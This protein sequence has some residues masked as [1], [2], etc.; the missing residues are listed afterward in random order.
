VQGSA[1]IS[2]NA[3]TVSYGRGLSIRGNEAVYVVT[4]FQQEGNH[5]IEETVLLPTSLGPAV[6]G[7][8]YDLSIHW[9]G[10]TSTFTYRVLGLDDSVT[11]AAPAPLPRDCHDSR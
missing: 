9:D 11:I 8:H 5:S 4:V 1:A 7:N 6:L 2:V 3:M 10:P